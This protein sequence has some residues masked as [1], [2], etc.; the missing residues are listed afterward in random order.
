[1]SRSGPEASSN[2]R[3][4]DAVNR[5]RREFGQAGFVLAAGSFDL[6][7]LVLRGVF[8]D[9]HDVQLFVVRLELR[10]SPRRRVQADVG[11]QFLLD[12]VSDGLE[13]LL[14]VGGLPG[15]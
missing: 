3:R 11:V 9:A 2:A 15:V 7:P 14:R 12:S 6:E 1:M 10:N 8:Q 5:L 13:D 4:P